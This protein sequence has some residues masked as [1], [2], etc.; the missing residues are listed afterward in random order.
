MTGV[1]AVRDAS[2]KFVIGHLS[3]RISKK[4]FQLHCACGELFNVYPSQIILGKKYC[5]KQC[6]NVF[7]AHPRNAG[8]FKCGVRENL[9]KGVTKQCVVCSGG[10]YIKNSQ[11]HLRKTCSRKCAAKLRETLTGEDHPS[12]KGGFGSRRSHLMRR[13]KYRRWRTLV[14]HRDDYTCKKCKQRGG[15]LHADHI[16]PWATHP[17]LRYKLSNGRTLCVDCHRKRHRKVA[18]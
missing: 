11:A 3:L 10:F 8:Q 13:K 6:A 4:R 7:S 2:G 9:R 5:S 14:F 1:Q 18:I 15:Y 12:W 16:K 17:V